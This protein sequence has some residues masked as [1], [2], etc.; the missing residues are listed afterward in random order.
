MKIVKVRDLLHV[1]EFILPIDL[2]NI[3]LSTCMS[4]DLFNTLLVRLLHH[5]DHMAL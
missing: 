5:F 1:R 4:H 2:L 3:N